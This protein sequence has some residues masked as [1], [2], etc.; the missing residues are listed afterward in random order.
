MIKLV[1]DVPIGRVAQCSSICAHADKLAF[2]RYLPFWLQDTN[3]SWKPFFD[4]VGTISIFSYKTLIVF[5]SFVLAVSL[6]SDYSVFLRLIFSFLLVTF[7]S[8]PV[9]YFF[10]VYAPMDMYL[11]NVTGANFS[12]DMQKTL[13]DYKPSPPLL[14][15]I[16]SMRQRRIGNSLGVTTFPS[17]HIGWS[18]IMVFFCFQLYRPLFYVMLP[19]SL[20]NALGTIFTLQHYAVDIPAGIIVAFVSIFIAQKMFRFDGKKSEI[21]KMIK[22]DIRSLIDCMRYVKSEACG[23]R[24]KK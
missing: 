7:I 10:P 5:L 23:L 15:F 2:G 1:N 6:A 11:D 22:A 20:F 13:H 18:V 19:V 8:L 24:Q 14:D 9:W 12:L 16:E 3:N 4:L 21:T 17:M